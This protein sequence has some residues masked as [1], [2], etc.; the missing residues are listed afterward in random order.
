MNPHDTSA[1]PDASGLD[2]REF[3]RV[4]GIAAA[5][6][7]ASAGCQP[8][9]EPTIPFHDMPESLVAGLGRARFYTTV[10]DGSPVLVRTREGR[11]ILV[12]P[13]PEDASGR[14]LSVRH[15]AAIMDL[16]D[17]DRA[18]GPLSVRRG[19][20]AV[21]SSSW[22]VVDAEVVAK[23]KAAGTRAVL[24]TAPVG[25]PTLAAAIAALTATTGLR[26]VA[27]AP[28]E[29]DGAAMAWT[30]AF[31][32]ARL[33][34]PRLDRADLLVG[35]G[36][37]FL[38]R[39]DDGLERDFSMRRSPDQP[40]GGRMSRFVQL[41]GRL[42]L[43]GANADRRI[44]VRDSHLAAV[45]AALAH[46]LVVVRKVG[47][48]AADAA[49]GTALAPFAI[50]TI[51]PKAGIDAGVLRA[52]AG[53]LAAAQGKALDLAGGSA[54]A[55]A[56]GPA[57]EL[58]AILLNITTGAFEGGLFDEATA[59]EAASGGGASL[60]SLVSEM[61]AGRVELLIVAGTNP[62]YDGPAPVT[63]ADALAK[64]PF[65]VSLNDRV[66]ETSRLADVLAPTSHPF[67][68]WG[69][70]AL[71]K[72]LLA[73][74]QPV[75]QALFDTRGLLDVLVG[76]GA[77]LG[78]PA[79]VAAAKAVTAA[80]GVAPAP[81]TAAPAPSPSLAWHYLRAAWASR[82]GMD[83]S[84][85]AF[86]GAWTTVLRSGNWSAS[87]APA[88]AA[89][90]GEA[91]AAQTPAAATPR[92]IAPAA[93]GLLASMPEAPADLELQLYPHLAL[94]DGRAGNNGWLLEFPDPVTRITWGG[95]VS[96]APRRFDEMGLTSGD[97][98]EVDAG[99]AKVVAPAY[100]H[101]G[102]HHDQ[103]ALP[104]GLGRSACGAIGNGVGPNAFPL[105][106]L[107][108]GRVL[109][110]G[111]AV[112]LRKA[113]G[114]EALAFAQGSDVIDRQRRPL[115]PTATLTAYEQDTRAGT[116]QQKGG[117]SIWPAHP[118]PKAHWAMA[119]DLSRC[120]GCGKCVIACQA[121][122]NVPVV[123]RHGMLMGREMSWMRIDRY[124]DAPRKDGQWGAE[125]WDGPLEVVEEPQTLF[126]PMLCQH[127]ENAP[128][129][130]VCPFVATM[131]SEDGL[132][133][134]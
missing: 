123:G 44:R 102:M 33:A 115:V 14:G 53:E 98:V 63:F 59:V 67:E 110:S 92:T 85:P 11:P 50:D 31:G 18:R 78:E 6:A 7:L 72:A 34:R 40:E 68:C 65:V 96:I 89:A 76:W 130:T 109:S 127:C 22:P 32:D 37:E 77:A 25:S 71:P 55:T 64:V 47:P 20:G 61:L 90:G 16:Y 133:Q 128:C 5:G 73:V 81:A 30:Q 26:H 75:V 27:W 35:L 45:G 94:A 24:L 66:D 86:E 83:P 101:A 69:D 104:L 54:G 111:L 114:H 79:A 10:I 2:R 12:A 17:P 82:M 105:R 125:V 39:P 3:L 38:D 41:E 134:Q 15:H 36:A 1:Q 19:N 103:V 84:T 121:E 113:G 80:L 100:R 70:A 58:A 106:L 87:A 120:D 56:S 21:V 132:N 4:S 23:L 95:A 122:N 126:E 51:A 46:E 116:E 13:S 88:P 112:T 62:V 42:T 108:G 91:A 118:F 9:P 48:L 117:P 74:Q 129:E 131:H 119:I 29:N 99:H 8:P 107:A 124:Y 43:T 49:V 57:I 60:A 93:L 28:L 97:L 52:L